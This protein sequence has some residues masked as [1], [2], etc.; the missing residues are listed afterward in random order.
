M[1][2]NR[3]L[4]I[5]GGSKFGKKTSLGLLEEGYEVDII[6]STGSPHKDIKF[7]R[8]NWESLNHYLAVEALKKFKDGEPYT[9]IIFNQN[10]GSSGFA[11]NYG[12]M[13]PQEHAEWSQHFFNNVQLIDIV[14]KELKGRIIP[15]TK[16]IG[17]VSGIIQSIKEVNPIN[18][19]NEILAERFGGYAGMKAYIYYMMQGYNKFATGNYITVNPGH[20]ETEEQQNYFSNGLV[21]FIKEVKDT[22]LEYAMY[23]AYN[24]LS[25]NLGYSKL[26]C[27]NEFGS[28]IKNK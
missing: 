1:T 6:T 27:I 14:I 13:T 16:I 26:T 9:E 10:A 21:Q 28:R 15:S 5:G 12:I 24:V 18:G 7:S 22:K 17:L 23:T 11:E 19:K 3:V 8:V 20:M 2:K 25:G 4:I